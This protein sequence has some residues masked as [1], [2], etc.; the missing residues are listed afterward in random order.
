MTW[1]TTDEVLFSL[2]AYLG[3]MV[4]LYISYRIGLSRPFWAVTTA[5]VVSQPWSGAVRSKAIYRLGG[6]FIGSAVCVFLVPRLTN[7]PVLLCLAMMAW[8][9][10]CVYVS[11]L[12][13][14]P[15]S[16]LFMLAGYTAGMI[17]FPSVND[18][19]LVF[20]TALSR[21]EEISLG[22]VCATLAHSLILPR[23]MGSMVLA[24]LDQ[25]INDARRWARDAL[26]RTGVAGVRSA[27]TR[28]EQFKLANDITQ[29]RILS[30]HIPYDT[31]NIRFTA[32][33]VHAMQDAM[34]AM[35]PVIAAIEDRLDAL[36]ADDR[37]LPTAWQ[38]IMD[39]LAQWMLP[40]TDTAA[41]ADTASRL[42]AAIDQ[43]TPAL[44][45]H[46]DWRDALLTSLA[47][48]MHELIDL[49]AHALALRQDIASG[50]RGDAASGARAGLIRAQDTSARAGWS[51]R[52]QAARPTGGLD[53]LHRDHGVAALSG[54][55]AAI[56]VAVCSAFWIATGWSN[57][58]T[59]VLMAAIFSSFFASQ[60]NPVPG[61]VVFLKFTLLSMPLSAIYLLGIIPALHSFEMVAMA[62][63]PVAFV[64]GIL[65]ARP[66][67]TLKGMAFFFGFAGTLALHDT[68]TANLVT[69]L[70]TNIAQVVGVGTA[71]LIAALFRNISV[72]A[73]ARRIQAAGWRELAQVATAT[74]APNA[75]VFNARRLDRVGLLQARLGTTSAVD[76]LAADALLDLRIGRD[77]VDLQGQRDALPQARAALRALLAEL[78][79]LFRNRARHHGS[80]VPA[81]LLD[82]I[83]TALAVVL[84]QRG[85]PSVNSGAVQRTV[86]ALVGLRRALFP[87][88]APYA[89]SSTT[90]VPRNLTEGGRAPQAVAAQP[91]APGA[92]M[93]AAPARHDN[94]GRQP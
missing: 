31:S 23:S 78:A 19:S 56:A 28:R 3:A 21:V 94:P 53:L 20:D 10:L 35:T 8:I 45:P 87:Q 17:A 41:P 67:Y 14:T 65:I 88:A 57:G 66:A 38:G 64:M 7:A 90:A 93:P 61:I 54:L 50:V 46:S 9:G 12:D 60:D 25:A 51:A 18:P 63:F 22:I 81:A 84:D 89:R 68:Q 1:P 32:R 30:T 48:R 39:D 47:V 72:A 33:S 40:A 77:M 27:A 74:R 70:D 83:D 4:A 92:V 26:A 49:H 37:A 86:V 82:R 55:A 29:L 24:G 71:A 43:A 76:A 42:H 16:Y 80:D 6:T 69:F 59:A 79:K 36:T 62:I 11:V 5:Y 91:L 52:W 44:A 2:K 34:A 13:R 85:D 15:R 73:S 58:A 75:Y